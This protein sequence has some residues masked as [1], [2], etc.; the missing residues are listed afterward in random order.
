MSTFDELISAGPNLKLLPRWR[1]IDAALSSIDGLPGITAKIEIGQ[2]DLYLKTAWFEGKIVRLDITLSRGRGVDDGL[3][4]SER[5]VNLETTRFDLAR[6]WVENECRMASNLLQTG[7]AGIGT[8]TEEWIGV[9]GYPSGHCK[10]L[11]GVN[12]ETGESGPTFQRGPLTAAGMLIQR[13][14]VEWTKYIKSIEVLTNDSDDG[15]KDDDS[16]G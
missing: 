9:E 4:L 11:P 6:S 8:I 14:L 5:Q 16:E 2:H 15:N 7:E 12:P 10:Q 13:R 1:Q 3:P